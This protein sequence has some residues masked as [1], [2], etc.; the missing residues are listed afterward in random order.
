MTNV[1][2]RNAVNR[3]TLKR[4]TLKR[5]TLDR[6]TLDTAV[7][8]DVQARGGRLTMPRSR[9]AAS[10]LVVLALGAW[11]A[12][13]PFV[14]PSL[15][16][17]YSLGSD[18][19]VGRGW[20][21]VLPGVVAIVG[22]LLLLT[23]RNRIT[24]MLGGWLAAA[25][26]AWFVIGRALAGPLGLGD[27]GTPVGDTEAQQAWVE[28]AYFSGVG[29]LLVLFAAMALGRLSVRSVRDVEFVQRPVRRHDVAAPAAPA[30]TVAAPAAAAPIED[31]RTEVIRD[32]RPRRGGWR[33]ALRGRSTADTTR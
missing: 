24:G 4:D 3:D 10:G 6:D 25:A 21:E 5:D 1:V 32:E 28:L 20:L 22:G 29:V 8:P 9:G 16:M 19:T 30:T 27:V 15:G 2:N 33:A 14:A 13:A 7:A 11:G 23:S 12:A 18:W 17:S 31:A 26:G